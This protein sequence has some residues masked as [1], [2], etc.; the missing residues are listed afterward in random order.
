M[1]NLISKKIYFVNKHNHKLNA[2]IK[3]C[4][5]V[6]WN[7][8]DLITIAIYHKISDNSVKSLIKSKIL[9]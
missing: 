9:T 3:Q 8:D 2:N 1:K 4:Y 7:D 5:W 6:A